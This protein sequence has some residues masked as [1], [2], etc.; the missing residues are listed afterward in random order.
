MEY[1]FA[2]TI[3]S[4][5]NVFF[6]GGVE[7]FDKLGKITII[8]YP[9]KEVCIY[10]PDLKDDVVQKLRAAENNKGQNTVHVMSEKNFPDMDDDQLRAI[11]VDLNKKI[12]RLDPNAN[13]LLSQR[14]NLLVITFPDIKDEK[15]SVLDLVFGILRDMDGLKLGYVITAVSV[16]RIVPNK[17]SKQIP[18]LENTEHGVITQDDIT[19]LIIDLERSES[20]EDLLQ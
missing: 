10:H 15:D 6:K 14:S 18:K 2:N 20:S 1:M 19:N 5:V 9:A 13:I 7:E 4:I 11:N 16:Y 8:P 3:D 12:E 17:R